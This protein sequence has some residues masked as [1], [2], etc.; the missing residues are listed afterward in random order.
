MNNSWCRSH[1]KTPY[2][3]VYGDKPCG[4]CTLIDELFAKNIYNEEDIPDT[5]QIFEGIENLDDD[6]MDDL[7]G[8]ISIIKKKIYIIF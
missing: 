4:N 6:M 8:K 5:I 7:R 2:E 1:K 3:L